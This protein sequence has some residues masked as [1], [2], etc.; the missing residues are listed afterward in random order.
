MAPGLGVSVAAV[1]GVEAALTTMPPAGVA[2]DAGLAAGDAAAEVGDAARALRVAGGAVGGGVSGLAGRVA[3]R[4]TAEPSTVVAMGALI[5]GG[6]PRRGERPLS[7]A[8]SESSRAMTTAAITPKAITIRWVVA[9]P[10]RRNIVKSLA[11]LFARLGGGVHSSLAERTGVN[12]R[13]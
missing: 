5:V 4:S 12:G 2:G 3:T 1:R 7:L 8:S 6:L 10:P 9:I 11:R 13:P